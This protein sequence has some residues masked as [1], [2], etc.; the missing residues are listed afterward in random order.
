MILNEFLTDLEVIEI[1]NTSDGLG[2]YI[3]GVSVVKTLQGI[4]ARV[5]NKESRIAEKL[6]NKSYYVLYVKKGTLID[7]NNLVRRV[8]DNRV[9]R[10]TSLAGD[11]ITPSGAGI[12]FEKFEC[13][14]YEKN[15]I[16]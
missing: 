13:E 16:I 5:S 1:N 7:R 10:I 12:D 11:K 2:G 8:S 3:E 14:I 15:D 6:N 9:F 4:I